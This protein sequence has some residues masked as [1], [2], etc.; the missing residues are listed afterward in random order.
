MNKHHKRWSFY[1]LDRIYIFLCRDRNVIFSK[2]KHEGVLSILFAANCGK[3]LSVNWC[4]L[5]GG[6]GLH[7]NSKSVTFQ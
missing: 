6:V 7:P 2:S 5:D 4:A 1:W 3:K